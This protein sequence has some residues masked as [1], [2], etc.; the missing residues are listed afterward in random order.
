[1]YQG[2]KLKMALVFE[3]V[4]QCD[5]GITCYLVYNSVL[6]IYG[7]VECM[8]LP[9]MQKQSATNDLSICRNEQFANSLIIVE[10]ALAV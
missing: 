10:F 9:L 5:K 4:F 6:T 2:V 3:L 7:S 8:L 1:M